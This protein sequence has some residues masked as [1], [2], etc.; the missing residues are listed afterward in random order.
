MWSRKKRR[1]RAIWSMPA[2][3]GVILLLFDPKIASFI[4]SKKQ[5]NT[6]NTLRLHFYRATNK[7]CWFFNFLWC[8]QNTSIGLV[9]FLYSSFSLFPRLFLVS[10]FSFLLSLSPHRFYGSFFFLILF[11][12]TS[13]KL[14]WSLFSLF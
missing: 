3:I 7:P 14:V 6:P 5:F 11:Y 10:I 1:N 9:C 13:H 8:I 2:D 12:F 4:K